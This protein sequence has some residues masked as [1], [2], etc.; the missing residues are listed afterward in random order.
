MVDLKKYV[1]IC[2]F[3]WVIQLAAQSQVSKSVKQEDSDKVYAGLQIQASFPGGTDSFVRF[4]TNNF[5]Y[6]LRCQDSG[7]SGYVLLRFVVEK[8][9][10]VKNITVLEE[11]KRCP[12]FSKEAVRVLSL[13]PP[14]IPGKVDGSYVRS[15]RV[16]PIRLSLQ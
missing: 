6:P 15:Y 13:S 8:D 5:V 2:L 3:L 4:I 12:E 7:I 16:L 9:G 10:K 11:T 14:W 1:S